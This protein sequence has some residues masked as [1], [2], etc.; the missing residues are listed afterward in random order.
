[1]RPH[2]K[3]ALAAVIVLL[4]AATG[5]WQL[6]PA[7]TDEPVGGSW[8]AVE[9]QSI[10][11]PISLKGTLLPVNSVNIVSP[12]DGRLGARDVQFGDKVSAGQVLAHIDSAELANQLREAEIGT[13]RAEQE[14]DNARHLED[15]TEYKAASRRVTTARN[16]L[17]TS[18]RHLVETQSLY[19]KGIIARTELEGIQ[20]ELENARSQVQSSADEIATLK[21]KQSNSALRI[22]HLELDSRRARLKELREKQGAT[23]LASP[24][25]GVVLYPLQSDTSDSGASNA[26]KEFKPGAFIS[27]RDVILSVGDTS[28]FLVKIWVDETDVKSIE[29]NQ[30]A[31]VSLTAEPAYEFKGSVMRV[32]SQARANDQRN[33]S[34]QG[35]VAFEVQVLIKP[36]TPDPAGGPVPILR[37]GASATVKLQPEPGPPALLVPL[38]ALVWTEQGQP[39]I[40]SRKSPRESGHLRHVE[41]T[42]TTVDFAELR[43]GIAEGDEVWVPS[44][45]DKTPSG[46]LRNLSSMSNGD[47]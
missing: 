7:G 38:S 28:A 39:A 25:A 6:S 10:A 8:Q 41:V 3:R 11:Q 34:G 13:I 42:R 40:R 5:W 26:T 43:S 15:G 35:G 29:L 19:D 1:M 14:L 47:E 9:R 32:S 36:P 46:V 12:V 20:Q 24:I 45:A 23:Q 33:A 37:V 4:V 2:S 17:A 22:L 16:A 31:T 44:L 27:N 18:E 21:L 30:E